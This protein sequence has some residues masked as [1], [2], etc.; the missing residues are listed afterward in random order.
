M[1]RDP[2]AVRDL[3]GKYGSNTTPTFVIYEEVV[4]GFR[5]ERLEELI[6][7]VDA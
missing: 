3:I 2:Q 4:V 6:G 1:R 5:R 7:P